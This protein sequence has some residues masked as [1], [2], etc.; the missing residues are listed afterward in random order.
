MKVES[1]VVRGK[2]KPGTV[3]LENGVECKRKP[4]GKK[5]EKNRKRKQGGENQ[6]PH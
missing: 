3:D 2:V 1:A 4:E 6:T 5:T